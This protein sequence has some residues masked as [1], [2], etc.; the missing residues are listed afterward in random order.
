MNVHVARTLTA[1][2]AQDIRGNKCEFRG[3]AIARA[4]IQGL[5][6]G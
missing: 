1:M 3:E 5:G 4:R 6:D 2:Q